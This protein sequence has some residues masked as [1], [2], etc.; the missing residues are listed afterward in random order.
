[1]CV[2][3]GPGPQGWTQQ[4][5]WSSSPAVEGLDLDCNESAAKDAFEL[6][7]PRLNW[8]EANMFSVVK[9]ASGLWGSSAE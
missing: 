9:V 8:S 2:S 5:F 4:I 7:V 1:M 3:C 6:Q